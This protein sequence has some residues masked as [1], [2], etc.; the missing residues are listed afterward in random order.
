MKRSSTLYWGLLGLM[1]IVVAGLIGFSLLLFLQGPVSTSSIFSSDV[2]PMNVYVQAPPA[3]SIGD[4]IKMVVTVENV[5]DQFRQVDEIRLPDRLMEV[6]VVKKVFPALTS[7]SV[8]QQFYGDQT[9]FKIGLTLQPGESRSF[10]ITLMP[11]QIADVTGDI[12]VVSGEQHIPASF[13]LAFDKAVAVVLPTVTSTPQLPTQEPTLSPVPVI[14][15]ATAPVIPYNSVV[16]IIA[17]VKWGPWLKPVWSGSG[18]IV[19]K[20]GLIL[21]N[22]HLVNPG[23]FDKYDYMVI[24]LTV[25]PATEPIEKYMA[26]PIVT[27]PKLDIAILQINTDLKYNP[28]DLS[29]LD[30]PVMPLG[31]S[32]SLQLGDPITILGYPG[33]GGSTITLTGGNVGG[34]T[35]QSQY[36]LRAFI[37]TAASISGGTSGGMVMDK[38][39][40]LVA[41]PTQ[42]G[43]GG[44]DALV[45]CRVIQD[46]NGDGKINAKDQCIPVGGFINALRPVNLA[47]PLIEEARRITGHVDGGQAQ[48]SPSPTP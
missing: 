27:D 47:I 44:D 30:L 18:T 31:D 24:A 15:T 42:L 13:R 32:D 4:E 19:S 36:G 29:T 10:E 45:D 25:D 33:I 37:K 34:F 11:W 16:R 38:N 8:G 39:G 22:A 35:E 5:G 46:T 6:A 40:K 41:I 43:S 1:F 2:K 26:Q 3:S 20:D 9:G 17:K 7:G 14:P 28:I 21:T 12:E 23:P 48:P